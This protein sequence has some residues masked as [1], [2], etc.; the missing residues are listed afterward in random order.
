M[1]HLQPQVF[2]Y[3]PMLIHEADPTVS[4]S[5]DHCYCTCRPSVPTFQNNFLVKTMV[6]T[7][8]SVGLAGWI[9]DDNCLVYLSLH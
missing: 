8:E 4:V 1:R 5:S 9:I 2:N 7:G 6:V 3:D